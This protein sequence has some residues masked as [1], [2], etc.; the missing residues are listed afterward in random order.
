MKKELKRIKK[1]KASFR[2]TGVESPPF[3]GG[4]LA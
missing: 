4:M 2:Q 1:L 3:L